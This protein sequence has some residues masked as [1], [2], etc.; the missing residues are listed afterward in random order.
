MFYLPLQSVDDSPPVLGTFPTTSAQAQAYFFGPSQYGGHDFVAVVDGVSTPIGPAYLAGPVT[1][2]PLLD[3]GGTHILTLGA[4]VQPLSPG[5][6]TVRISG[7]L[8]GAAL[9]PTYGITFLRDDFT[10]TIHVR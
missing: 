6:H 4:F 1:T 9:A 2:P 8:S 10:Y 5:T 7:E 3:G